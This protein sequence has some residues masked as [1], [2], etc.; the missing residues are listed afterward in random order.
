MSAN[1]SLPGPTTVSLDDEEGVKRIVID[2][3][4]GLWASV[5]TLSRLRPSKRNRY[6]VAVFGRRVRTLATGCTR[7]S[8]G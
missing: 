3:L 7:R 2:T 4:F 6:R 1:N 5:N 8:S